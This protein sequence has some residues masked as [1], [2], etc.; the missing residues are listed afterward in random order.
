MVSVTPVVVMCGQPRQLAALAQHGL[1]L[2][3]ALPQTADAVRILSSAEA[4]TQLLH[5]Y[6]NA[7][8]TVLIQR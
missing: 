5:P 6:L 1:Q 3:Q 7:P 4:E 2:R 8:G